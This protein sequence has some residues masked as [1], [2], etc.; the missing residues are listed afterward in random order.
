V[1][2]P[3]ALGDPIPRERKKR[4][5]I[6]TYLALEKAQG[7]TTFDLGNG[8]HKVHRDVPSKKTLK[9]VHPNKRTFFYPHSVKKREWFFLK[10]LVFAL[11][12][13]FRFSTNTSKS[14]YIKGV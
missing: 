14:Y 10:K 1:S 3:E 5:S 11:K 13:V 9:G 7:Y 8:P 12:K 6:Q 2:T 4:I